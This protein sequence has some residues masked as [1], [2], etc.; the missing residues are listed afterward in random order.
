MQVP[1]ESISAALRI[2]RESAVAK[3]LRASE[4]FAIRDW[5]E[6]RSRN[7]DSLRAARM[8]SEGCGRT[9]CRGELSEKKREKVE[10]PKGPVAFLIRRDSA[11]S[12]C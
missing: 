9:L 12:Q 11:C 1:A 8:L 5:L 6:A 3:G 4:R 10:K 7:S 2:L